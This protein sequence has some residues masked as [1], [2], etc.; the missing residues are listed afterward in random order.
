M[1]PT[2]SLRLA[3]LFV[4]LLLR[5]SACASLALG[6][7]LWLPSLRADITVLHTFR[8]ALS[9][10]GVNPRDEML[11]GSD[12]FLYGTTRNTVFRIRP[13]GS[14]YQ[15]IN[16]F[17]SPGPALR[18]GRIVEGPDRNLY[19]L[20]SSPGPVV[21]RLS[22]DGATR[23]IVYT[24]PST[25]VPTGTLG[26]LT[27]GSDGRLYGLIEMRQGTGTVAWPTLFGLN[28]DGT[29]FAV[30][31]VFATAA[32]FSTNSGTVTVPFDEVTEGLD[33]RL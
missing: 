20:A 13:D 33:G 9:L 17:L 27:A 19:G 11:V 3:A 16:R 23:D 31:H 6:L 15:T 24:F 25:A 7:L 10:D 4:S 26:G 32:D 22:R 14:D 30:L 12:G 21:Y 28:P 2:R 5:P 1:L 8:F 18:T 29:G